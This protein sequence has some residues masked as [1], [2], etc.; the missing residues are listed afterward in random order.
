MSFA[1][2]HPELS[3]PSRS[4]Q[5]H[6]R[7]IRIAIVSRS[8]IAVWTPF[9]FGSTF[10]GGEYMLTVKKH[11]F[12]LFIDRESQQWIVRDPEGKFWSVP[13]GD[14]AWEHREPFDPVENAEL[15]P[16]PGH[17]KYLLRLPF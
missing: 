1:K 6:R 12:G 10:N 5:I 17:Y 13:S 9:R 15:E 2:N 3:Y 11:T 8:Q 16:V 4:L 7:E 14:D